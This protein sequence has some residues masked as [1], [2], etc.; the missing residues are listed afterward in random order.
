M[1]FTPDRIPKKDHNKRYFNNHVKCVSLI[2]KK[3]L[4][5]FDKAYISY[6]VR[7]PIMLIKLFHRGLIS[8]NILFLTDEV[9]AVVKYV[10]NL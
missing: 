2:K 9:F 3:I 4:H 10:M 6:L 5:A 8:N 7:R 1:T